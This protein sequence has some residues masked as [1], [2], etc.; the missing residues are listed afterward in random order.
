LLSYL[1]YEFRL[2]PFDIE[3]MKQLHNK[4]NIVPI[5][6]KA[7]VLTKIEVAQLK[8][9]VYFHS[10]IKSN[11]HIIINLQKCVVIA[12]VNFRRFLER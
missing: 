11:I 1:L 4:V 12:I 3:F 7:D 10:R 8:K 5:I 6:A 9:K 2:K